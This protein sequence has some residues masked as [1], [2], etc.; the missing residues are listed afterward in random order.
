M[1][2]GYIYIH[3]LILCLS[4]AYKNLRQILDSLIWFW[5]LGFRL[6]GCLNQNILFG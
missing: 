1:I 5:K 6:F 3:I 4:L 2:K